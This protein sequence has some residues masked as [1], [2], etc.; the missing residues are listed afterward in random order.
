MNKLFIITFFAQFLMSSTV[1]AKRDYH[2]KWCES[3]GRVLEIAIDSGRRT[4]TYVEEKNIL[5]TAVTTSIDEVP[6]KDNFYFLQTLQHI[7]RNV[8]NYESDEDK[9]HYLRSYTK[10]ALR[11]LWYLDEVYYSDGCFFCRKDHSEYVARI[12]QRSLTEGLASVEDMQENTLLNIGAETGIY[13]LNKSAYRRSY[14]C[15]RKLLELSLKVNDVESKRTYL[16]DA[17]RELI[18]NTCR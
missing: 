8:Q 9:V 13:Y 14:R 10:Y 12:L 15:A 6:R 4:S 1:F 18:Y 3:V 2:I 5:L 11:D 16:K 7:E 17:H